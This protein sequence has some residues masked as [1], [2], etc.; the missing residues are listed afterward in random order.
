MAITPSPR[1]LS[2]G[3]VVWRVHF[4]IPPSRTATSKTFET[5]QDADQ[6][7][8]L[9]GRVGPAAARALRLAHSREGLSEIITCKDAFEAY[10]K[11]AGASVEPGTLEKYRSNWRLYAAST[12]DDWPI[13]ALP[14]EVIEDWIVSLRHRETFYSIKARE[15]AK[16]ERRA[17]PEKDYLAPK[18]IQNIQGILSSALGLQVSRGKLAKNPAR[19]VRLPKNRRKTQPVFLSFDQRQ[20]LISAVHQV[21]LERGHSRQ[22]YP[23]MV[24]FDLS[25]GLRWGEVTALGPE[26]FDLD[27]I[28]PTVRVERAWKYGS[29]GRLGIT[30]SEASDRTVSFPTDLI[31]PIRNLLQ[32]TSPGEMVFPGPKG[33]RLRDVW[34]Y[35][36][37]WS[38][39]L[40]AAGLTNPYPRFHDLRHTHASMLIEQNAPLPYIQARLGHEDIHTTV[41]TYG[42]LVTNIQEIMAR[43]TEAAM[44]GPA[45]QPSTSTAPSLTGS[46]LAKMRETL[47]QTVYEFADSF[48]LD[49]MVLAYLEATNQALPEEI[50]N[51]LRTM[52]AGSAES[53]IRIAA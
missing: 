29:D 47:D 7:I 52:L 48:D 27:P 51:K 43:A 46:A 49:P 4:R 19:G 33:G 5:Y 2:D 1:T 13:D 14:V 3:T 25:T 38:H 35:Q 11:H 17:Q 23:V 20:S 39:A 15:R 53:T 36:A 44:R 40:E 16:E 12:F 32:R 18:T 24:E 41:K 34:F 45:N 21:C 42:H 22:I 10:C 26:H 37:I 9:M 8:A 50:T 6:F 31:E 28:T 30:K